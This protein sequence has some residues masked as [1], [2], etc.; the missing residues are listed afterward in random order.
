MARNYKL[1]QRA[2]YSEQY[3]FAWKIFASWDF[4]IINAEMVKAKA[5]QITVILKVNKLI[6]IVPT[7]SNNST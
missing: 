2:N 1:L 6:R 3:M 5:R 4:T 7:N